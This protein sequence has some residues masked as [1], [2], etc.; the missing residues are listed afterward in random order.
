MEA[1]DDKKVWLPG[2]KVGGI[3]HSVPF[4]NE[5]EIANFKMNDD[6]L[7]VKDYLTKR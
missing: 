1:A 5:P 7:V 4:K 6:G 2:F 3:E